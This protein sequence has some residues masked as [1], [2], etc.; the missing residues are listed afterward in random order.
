MDKNKAC[1][2]FFYFNRFETTT[3]LYFQGFSESEKKKGKLSLL[4][5]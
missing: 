2:N 3:D 4:N 5:S 1:K